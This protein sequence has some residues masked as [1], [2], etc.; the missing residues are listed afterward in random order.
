MSALPDNNP[1]RKQFLDRWTNDEIPLEMPSESS[2]PL[3]P[4]P[5]KVL[6]QLKADRARRARLDP[7][8]RAHLESLGIFLTPEELGETEP[9]KTGDAE[10]PASEPQ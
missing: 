6:R 8:Y 9:P 4:L 1:K 2:L 3:R 7:K 10:P 5:E